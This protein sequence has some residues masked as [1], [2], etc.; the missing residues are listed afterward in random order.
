MTLQSGRLAFIRGRHPR[1][2]PGSCV[3]GQLGVRRVV[4]PP[5]GLAGPGL[6]TWTTVCP[7][8]FLPCELFSSGEAGAQSP[9]RKGGRFSFLVL[10]GQS[11]L[12]PSLS[13]GWRPA[14][15]PHWPV[16]VLTTL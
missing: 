12:S 14:S 13:R 9:S 16:R 2:H 11:C 10:G 1:I 5:E 7:A 15:T 8:P 6:P 4:E 3:G